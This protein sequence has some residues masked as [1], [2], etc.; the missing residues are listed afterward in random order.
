MSWDQKIKND[1]HNLVLELTEQRDELINK[2]SAVEAEKKELLAIKRERDKLQ[3]V[4]DMWKL[5]FY[6]DGETPEKSNL[7]SFRFNQFTEMIK[8]LDESS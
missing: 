1:L 2:L 3:E 7:K 6:C 8:K 5:S 4:L